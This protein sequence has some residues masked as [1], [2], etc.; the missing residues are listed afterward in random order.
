MVTCL[1]KLREL[2][3]DWDEDRLK[4][5]IKGC[6][7]STAYIMHDPMWCVTQHNC[8]A[9]WNREVSEDEYNNYYETTV[10]LTGEDMRRLTALC[11]S[12]DKSRSGV[13]S[14]ALYFLEQSLL[15][16]PLGGV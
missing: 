4:E 13:V 8:E 14:S 5:C 7:P 1:E 12:V 10:I 3:P 2:K 11:G 9:C 6:C 15:Y 16:D